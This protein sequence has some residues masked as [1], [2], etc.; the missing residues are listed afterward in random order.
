MLHGWASPDTWRAE[1]ARLRT[2][3]VHYRK[4]HY[5]KRA[6]P[7]RGPDSAEAFHVSGLE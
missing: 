5:G 1:I 7:L 4:P 3:L 2:G 6:S